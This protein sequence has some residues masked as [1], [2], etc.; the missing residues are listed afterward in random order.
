MEL[1]WPS[2]QYLP[3]YV[4]ALE[5]GWSPDNLRPEAGREEL[6][7]IARDPA[8]FVAEQVDREAKGPPVVLPDGTTVPRLPGY[9]LW[10]WDGEF[11]GV[12]GFRWQPGTTELPPHCL[13]HV[14]YS[15]VPWKQGRGYATRALR[16]LLPDARQE[17]LAYLELTTDASNVASQRVIEANGGRL[18]ERFFKPEGYGGAESLRYRIALE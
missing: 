13:G 7:R 10:M 11:C 12:I 5:Q 4:H 14:G 6:E 3:G 1:V 18:V 17:G 2:M 16:L 9:H 8:R 15:V